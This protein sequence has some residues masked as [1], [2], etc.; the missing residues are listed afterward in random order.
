M[1]AVACLRVL[2]DDNRTEVPA[3]ALGPMVA[4]YTGLF[5][6]VRW[7]LPRS[8]AP[9]NHYCYLLTDPR[10][11]QLD[12]AELALLSQEL[13][14]RLF[15]TG[16]EDG[17]QLVLFEGEPDA[18]ETFSRYSA[19]QVIDAM[20]DPSRL[21]SGARLR[22]VAEDGALIELPEEP[23][24]QETPGAFRPPPSVSGVQGIYFV[25]GATFVGDV[26]SSTP[27][28]APTYYSVLDGTEHRAPDAF[29][30]DMACITTALAFLVDYPDGGPLHL[31]VS[32]S[33]LMRPSRRR[34]YID[35][36]GVLPSHKRDDLAA[37]VYDTP[38]I[39]TYQAL[40]LVRA[41]LSPYLGQIGLRVTDPDFDILS[42]VQ[43]SFASV[44][45]DL[46]SASLENRLEAIRRFVEHFRDY[47]KRKI[48]PGIGNVRHPAE[49]DLALTLGVP[50]LSGP[51]VCRLRSQP[52]GRHAW[53]VEHL[54][55][56]MPANPP[57]WS[58][59]VA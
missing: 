6:E 52:V 24:P 13:Q 41:T 55:L 8:A 26:V 12:T 47:Q 19:D 57:P 54:P 17:V 25:R 20:R 56:P 29:A 9:L 36:L 3:E 2:V 48:W 23:S 33:T 1:T 11:T 39:P 5:L 21:P 31:P 18:I 45:L 44:T 28:T 50:F 7:T 38:R 30:F 51:G 22:R 58:L 10:S 37:N 43:S 34:A 46:P 15:G 53:A 14:S 32:F 4:K 27:V 40:G 59:A 49:R 42:L 16:A 35:L